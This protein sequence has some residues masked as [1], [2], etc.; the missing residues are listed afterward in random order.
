MEI[1]FLNIVFLFICFIGLTAGFIAFFEIKYI[2]FKAGKK[3]EYFVRKG[4][5]YEE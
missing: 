5:D 3:S 2:E 1:I 4:E